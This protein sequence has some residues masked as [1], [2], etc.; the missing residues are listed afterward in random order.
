[1]KKRRITIESQRRKKQAL[2]IAELGIPPASH[3]TSVTITDGQTPKND[4]ILDEYDPD[5]DLDIYPAPQDE[6][7]VIFS[8]PSSNKENKPTSYKDTNFF[9]SYTPSTLNLAED[10]GYGVHSGGNSNFLTAARSATMNL[11]N[12]DGAK[13]FAEPSRPKG[14][15]WDK[16]SKKYVARA[17]DEDGSK[18]KHMIKGESGQ[19]I[20]ATFRSGRF[21][22]W[23]KI[24]RIDRLPRTGETET[25][26]NAANIG[27]G[28]RWKHNEKKAPKEADRYR[29]DYYKRKKRVE[30]AKEERRGRFRDGGGK[31]EIRGVDD[32]RRERGLK[33]KK[34]EKNARPRK[35]R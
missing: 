3:E 10:R 30:K 1:M 20:A 29:D 23:R 25:V 7:E 14:M 11:T 8:Q 33:E 28:K 18:G 13:A 22:A 19:K 4:D 35:K 31:N 9:M 6:L 32:V 16:K 34:R 12:D 2:D 27:G 21:D 26:A 15:R 5:D 24:N 17:N